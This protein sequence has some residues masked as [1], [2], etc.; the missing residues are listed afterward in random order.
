MALTIVKP[1]NIAEYIGKDLGTTEWSSVYSCRSR[2]SNTNIWLNY[3]AWLSFSS[4]NRRDW[5]RHC[6]SGGGRKNGV[7]LWP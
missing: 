6:S 2:T 1:E 5:T 4:F 3:S 7:E